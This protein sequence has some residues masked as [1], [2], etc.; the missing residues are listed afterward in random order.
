MLGLRCAIPAHQYGVGIA[1]EDEVETASSRHVPIRRIVGSPLF[2][3]L[4]HCRVQDG[5]GDI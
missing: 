5:G 1:D 4:T 3:I 2:V